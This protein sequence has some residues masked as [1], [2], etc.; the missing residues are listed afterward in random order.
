MIVET[1]KVISIC[2]TLTDDENNVLDQTGQEQP[3]VYLHG[4]ENIISGLEEALAGKAS[5][6]KL[7]TRIEPEHAYGIRQEDKVQS[8]PIDSFQGVDKIEPGMQ[9]HA[10]GANGE[11]IVV[12]ITKIE[13]DKVTID[14]NHPL[15][16]VALTFDVEI[17]DIRKAT[18]DE[19]THKHVHGAG[20]DHG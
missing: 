13:G 5:G 18:A 7:K 16:G 11:N 12:T 3:M 8:M 17:M 4:A 9:F 6:D 1:N 10:A 19:L 20:C 2:Y 15:S 14:G